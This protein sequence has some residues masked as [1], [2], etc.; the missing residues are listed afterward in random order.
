[1]YLCDFLQSLVLTGE[2][3]LKKR[4][5]NRK[6]ENFKLSQHQLLHS[7]SIRKNRR[8]TYGGI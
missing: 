6:R 3:A 8:A 2:T 4:V 5:Y 7:M 1:M